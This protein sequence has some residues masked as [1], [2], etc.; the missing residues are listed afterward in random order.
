MEK[1][2]ICDVYMRCR[3]SLK[4]FLKDRFKVPGDVIYI[5]PTQNILHIS[6]TLFPKIREGCGYG[7]ESDIPCDQHK[8]LNCI[9]KIVDFLY[10]SVE[11]EQLWYKSF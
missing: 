8:F 11:E 9:Q 4:Y 1:I 3:Y 2:I 6:R 10:Y 7:C 5:M